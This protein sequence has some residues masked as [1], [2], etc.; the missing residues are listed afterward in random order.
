[1]QSLMS[2]TLQIDD[3]DIKIRTNQVTLETD[4]STLEAHID[5]GEFVLIKS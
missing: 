2:F 5:S 1:M 4:L 3:F